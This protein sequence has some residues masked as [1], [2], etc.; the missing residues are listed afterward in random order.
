MNIFTQYKTVVP[1]TLHELRKEKPKKK[2]K[3][4]KKNKIKPV[5][6]IDLLRESN[7]TN[8]LIAHELNF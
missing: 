2:T 3:R 4:D 6:A 5:T 8:L 1:P 7:R